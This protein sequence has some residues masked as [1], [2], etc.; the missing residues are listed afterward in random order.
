MS[1]G[2][3]GTILIQ[4]SFKV[5]GSTI[6]LIFIIWTLVSSISTVPF[7]GNITI[8]FA[9][10][11]NG[12]SSSGGGSSGKDKSSK[13][14]SSDN[15]GGSRAAAEAAAIMAEAAAAIIVEAEERQLQRTSGEQ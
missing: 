1:I 4:K 10:K 15:G 14:S 13:G 3:E 9:K 6:F 8:V 2:N 5:Y 7:T 12:S 11:H